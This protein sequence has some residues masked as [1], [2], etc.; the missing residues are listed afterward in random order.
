[1][2]T[3]QC[4]RCDGTGKYDR[5]DCFTCN[6]VGYKNQVTKPRCLT[7]QKITVTYENGSNNFVT[8]Y[9]VRRSVA[10][11]IVERMMSIKGW[12]GIAK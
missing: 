5:G 7:E 4:P 10:I 1:M 6:G 9:S 3:C 2:Y 11:S 8:I 12:K